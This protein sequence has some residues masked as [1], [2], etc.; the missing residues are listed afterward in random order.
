MLMLK[1]ESH[2]KIILDENLKC[3]YISLY[4]CTPCMYQNM[5]RTPYPSKFLKLIYHILTLKEYLTRKRNCFN[6]FYTTF[7]YWEH[8]RS[9]GI[10]NE[11]VINGRF[12][13]PR[14]DFWGGVH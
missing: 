11:V 1:L 12:L 8:F 4:V 5:E 6:T 9:F 7:S 3:V 2:L 13:N 10:I 14:T